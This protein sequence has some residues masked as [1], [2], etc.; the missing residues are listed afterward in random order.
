M[1]LPR[2]IFYGHLVILWSIWYIFPVLVC[3]TYKKNLATLMAGHRSLRMYRLIRS[4][5]QSAANEQKIDAFHYHYIS[6]AELD[7]G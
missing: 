7:N 4:A 2:D 6:A 5:E 1:L 3:C